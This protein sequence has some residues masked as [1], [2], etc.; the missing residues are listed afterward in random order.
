[1]QVEIAIS[2]AEGDGRVFLAWTPVQATIR[3]LDGPGAGQSIGVL[4]RNAGPG[5]QLLFDLERSHAGSSELPLDLPGDGSPVRFWIAGEFERASED[6]G[7]AVLEV[8]EATTSAPLGRSEMM[9]RVRKDAQTL[10][11]AERDR[12]LS[13][14]GILNGHGTGRF[15]EFRDMHVRSSLRESHGNYGFLPWHRA[16]LLDLERELQAIDARVSLPY[17]RFDKAAPNLFTP[18]FMGRANEVDRVIFTSNHPFNQ[19]M[20]DGD[21]GIVRQPLFPIDRAP[22]LRSEEHALD[23]GSGVFSR[24]S[25]ITRDQ[26]N[27]VI[28]RRS[29]IEIDPHGYAHTS[30]MGPIQSPP[31]APKD[32]LFFM[33]HAN[34]DRMWA[35]WQW[36]YRRTSDSDPNAYPHDGN[37]R[38]GHGI[39]DTMWPWNGV[40]GDPRPAT[41]PGGALA[42]STVTSAPG[43]SPTVRSMIDYQAKQGGAHLGFDYDDVPFEMPEVPVA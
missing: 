27:E 34:V 31:T 15:R 12:F 39:N 32:P 5:G 30:F 20:T 33:L 13:A 25:V 8:V 36:F 4:L 9:V 37:L 1:M 17:W 40:T 43:P 19:W 18:E 28:A 42:A 41:A 7:D 35:K 38:I 10:S 22:S 11:A 2:S 21:L 16:Y 24:F 3:L 23:F 29:G 26:N 14:F 6:F